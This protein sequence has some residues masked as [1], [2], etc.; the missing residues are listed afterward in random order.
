MAAAFRLR[1]RE[2]PINAEKALAEIK[3]MKTEGVPFTRGENGCLRLSLRSIQGVGKASK[4]RDTQESSLSKFVTNDAVK[5][6][7][8]EEGGVNRNDP[9]PGLPK[10]EDEA[11]AMGALIA[12]TR[13]L[14][15]PFSRAGKAGDGGMARSASQKL[16]PATS[17]AT[18]LAKNLSQLQTNASLSEGTGETE[19][20]G[21]SPR[22]C[23]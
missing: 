15:R 6:K 23:R 19:L 5:Q 9:P 2:D 1:F 3:R 12:W 17:S 10:T 22:P 7:E 21:I 18:T 8:P 13:T 11:V 4:V 14:Q 20:R 16:S